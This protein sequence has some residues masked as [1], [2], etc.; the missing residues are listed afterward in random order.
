MLGNV[1][2]CLRFMDSL[3]HSARRMKY[4]NCLNLGCPWSVLVTVIGDS[5]RIPEI[6]VDVVEVQEVRW[7]QG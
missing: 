7:D 5:T 3:K 2:H 6:E 4:R 1:A